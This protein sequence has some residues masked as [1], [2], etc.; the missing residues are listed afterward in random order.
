[1]KG[2]AYQRGFSRGHGVCGKGRDRVFI[3]GVLG[4]VLSW[5]VTLAVVSAGSNG[6]TLAQ[7]AAQSQR[8]DLAVRED[9]FAGFAGDAEAMSRGMKRC[10]EALAKDPK[11]A[12]AMVWHGSGLTFDAKRAFMAGDIEKGR[13]I[14]AQAMREMSDAVALR[15][16]DVSVLIPR[17]AVM[18]SAALHV[19]SQEVA[20]RD[21]QIAAD[22]YEKV[23]KLQTPVFSGMPVHSRGELLGGLAEAWNGLGNQEKLRA[24]L[25]RMVDELPGTLYADRARGILSTEPKPGALG[26]TCLGC[27][28]APTM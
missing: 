26:T 19:P 16:D 8:F 28:S 24:Y 21:F 3:L 27:H 5:M 12:E 20:K 25:Q 15:P 1:M 9:F 10:E 17:A 6:Q 4:A 7:G 18:I 23:L 14:Q 2:V 13:Q 11:N 22:D